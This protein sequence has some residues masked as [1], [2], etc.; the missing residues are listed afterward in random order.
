MKIILILLLLIGNNPCP[1]DKVHHPNRLKLLE[2]EKTVYG[3]VRKVK[4]ELDGDIHIRLDMGDKS[5]LTKNNIQHE[6]GCLVLEIVCV[7]E[8]IFT[9]CKDYKNK[10]LIPKVGDSIQV[11][12]PYVYD[13]IHGINEIHPV[14]DLIILK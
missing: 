10:T 5:L 1:C 3:I 9:I 14:N 2:K 6:D 4:G 13:K 12:G 7:K 11:T 8:S